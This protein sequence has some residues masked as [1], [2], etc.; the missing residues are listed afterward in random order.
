MVSMIKVGDN[1]LNFSLKDQN[2]KNFIL[3]EQ[4]GKYVLLSFHPL[5]WT[6]VCSGQMRSLEENKTTL[7]SLNAIA[8]GISIDSVPCKKAW[9]KSLDI[10]RTQ[11]LADFWPHGSIAQLYGVFRDKDGFSERANI[12]IDEKGNVAFTRVYEIKQLPDMNEIMDKIKRL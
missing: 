2:G 1:S 7:D 5:A 3:S 8:V 12:L 4:I 11:L 9:A 10:E 6:S